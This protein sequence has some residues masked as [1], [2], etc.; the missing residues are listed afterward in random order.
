M[1]TA[2]EIIEGAFGV[3][4]PE[5]DALAAFERDIHK[6]YGPRGLTD[7]YTSLNP[8]DVINLH[9][10]RVNPNSRSSGVGSAVIGELKDYARA[11][12]ATILLSPEADRGKKAALD[13]FYRR[14]GLQHNRGRHKDSR[15]SSMFAPTMLWRPTWE[16]LA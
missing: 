1:K 6:R 13:R 2:R 8:S 3:P 11:H 16:D 7:F 14:Q 4:T 15:L 10:L 5:Q 9:S 12:G